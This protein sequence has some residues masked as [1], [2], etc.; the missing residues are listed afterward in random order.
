[1]TT[2][3]EAVVWEDDVLRVFLRTTSNAS[4]VVFESKAFF[5]ISPRPRTKSLTILNSSW[6]LLPISGRQILNPILKFHFA[7]IRD[8]CGSA[9]QRVS[10]HF[11]KKSQQDHFPPDMW[12][13]SFWLNS[14]AML[15]PSLRSCWSRAAMVTIRAVSRPGPTGIS[16]WTTCW[17]RIS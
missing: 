17:P 9:V 16:T 15:Y 8:L 13:I 14:S 4:A 12:S 1:M 10:C 3:T 6:G 7:S 11:W 2:P 5:R